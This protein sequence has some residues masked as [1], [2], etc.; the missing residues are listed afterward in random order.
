[1]IRELRRKFFHIL[2]GIILII[3]IYILGSFLSLIIIGSMLLIGLFISLLIMNK[4]H[5][6]LISKIVEK[7][8]RQY[9]KK[10]PGYAAIMFF[11]AAIILLI[12]FYNNPILAIASLMTTIFGDG[13]AAIIG[14]K[15]GKHFIINQE[16][17]KK[18]I[19]GSLTLFLIS[20][21]CMS[22]FI[23]LNIAIIAGLTATLIEL[24]PL[25][26]NLTV[27]ISAG[28]IIKVLL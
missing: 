9:E 19:E 10:L 14:K 18:T 5:I 26:D 15:Y 28:I 23:P 7:V 27:P 20:T 12:L 22:F 6:P 17:Y 4:I 13:I 21:I 11:V 2:F 8:E 16:H 24:L 3:L 1:M 25:N